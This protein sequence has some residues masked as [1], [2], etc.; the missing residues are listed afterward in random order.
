MV[1]IW[2]KWWPHK[3]ILNL[4][5]LIC[6]TFYV[7]RLKC[8]NYIITKKCTFLD[9][10]AVYT[11]YPYVE[12]SPDHS[13]H[14]ETARLSRPM[15]SQFSKANFMFA[16]PSSVPLLQW[17]HAEEIKGLQLTTY[18]GSKSFIFF[19]AVPPTPQYYQIHFVVFMC[20]IFDTTLVFAKKS[21]VEKKLIF[22]TMRV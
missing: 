11:I 2:K 20:T 7:Q 9:S 15:N 19:L 21:N 6:I 14:V 13:I 4:T 22:V 1:G 5:D 8:L 10:Y 3:F 12:V 16:L 18:I 17:I